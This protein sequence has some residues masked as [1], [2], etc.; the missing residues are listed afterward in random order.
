MAN[1]FT[2]AALLLLASFI[3]GP[4][5]RASVAWIE[6]I[7]GLASRSH[8]V[9][10]GRVEKCEALLS[11]DGRRVYTHAK[12]RC[13]DVWHG[14]APTTLV[15][16][17]PGGTVGDLGQRVEGAP[18]LRPGEEVVLFLRKAGTAFSVAGLG[19]GKFAIDGGEATP[20]VGAIE[21]VPAPIPDGHREVEK[22][23]VVELERRVRSV[24]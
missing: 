1:R 16:K 23:P 10:R 11:A 18:T 6:T 8:A 15:V 24:P 2:A 14:A 5:A 19:Q 21:R 17:T 4:T 7:E 12:V 9:V 3:L 20:E 13:L 22:M